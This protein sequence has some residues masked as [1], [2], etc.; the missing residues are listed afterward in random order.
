MKLIKPSFEILEQ[1]PGLDGLLQHIERCGRTCYKSEDK[2]TEESAPKFVDM[3]VK[4]GHTAM[5]E[6]GTIYLTLN[7]ASRNEYFKYCTNKYSEAISEGEAEKGTWVGY[8]TTNYRVLLQNDWMEDLQYLTEPTKHI[9]R[10]TVKFICDR[11]VSHEF[12]RHRVFSFA[13]ESTR[14]CNYSKDKFGGDCTFIIPSWIDSDNFEIKRTLRW[15]ESLTY[16]VERI[17]GDYNNAP[18][19][20]YLQSLLQAEE[21]YMELLD[22]GWIAQQAR[23]VLPNSLKTELIMTGTIEQWEG[24][25]KLR[26]AKDA[27]PQARELAVP[28]YEEFVKRGYVTASISR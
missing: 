14:Y 18:L 10:I 4:R 27:H 7:M 23:A 9:K 3:L 17:T 20:M 8:V 21:A 26:C 16:E 19:S 6:H 2:I 28:L 24:F 13:Q 5:V 15:G 22:E 1:K 11:G 25:F 12:V